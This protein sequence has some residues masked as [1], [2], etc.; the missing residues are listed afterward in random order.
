MKGILGPVFLAL[1]ALTVQQG[2]GA[3]VR[4]CAT[5][6]P[7]EANAQRVTSMA[8]ALQTIA[9]CR[10]LK[11]NPV[12]TFQEGKYSYRIERK[13][14]QSIYTVTD[15]QQTISAPLSW[16]LGLGS[17][18]QTYVVEIEGQFYESRVSYFR[19][20]KALDLTLGAE[21]LHPTTLLQAAGRIINRPEKV[22]CFGCHSTN[23]SEGKQPMLDKLTPGVQCERCHGSTENHLAGLKKGDAQLAGMK[24]LGALSTEDLSNF[25]GQCHRTWE[26]IAAGG[27][28]SVLNV[29]FQPYG[30]TTSKCYDTEDSR[31]SCVA[32]HNPHEEVNRR[33]IDYDPKC[34]AC[35]SK[36]GKATAKVCAVAKSNCVSC[37]MP[38][39]ELPGAHYK[40]TD[41]DIRVVK[42][43]AAALKAPAAVLE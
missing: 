33:S 39:V 35:H 6:H 10:I 26:E 18:G 42:V 38:K 22:R 29:R 43:K 27:Q 41:H 14:E 37:H 31:I 8:N 4:E 12:L 36:G 34:Q 32:C 11:E 28:H 7:A 19:A 9:E 3:T 40:F 24:R 15:G 25:C 23:S 20:L 2:M 5:C 21:G 13:G 17:A 30:L 1:L 16:A